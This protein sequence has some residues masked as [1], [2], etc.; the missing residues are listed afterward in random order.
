MKKLLFAIYALDF[1]HA[2]LRE[3][4]KFVIIGAFELEVG[5]L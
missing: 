4:L 3:T 1:F 5:C 2:I